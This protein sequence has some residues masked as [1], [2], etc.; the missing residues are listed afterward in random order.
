MKRLA[1]L[2]TVP[3]LA[4]LLIFTLSGSAA[5]AQAEI[6]PTGATATP[7]PVY[8]PPAGQTSPGPPPSRA[9]VQQQITICA[10]GPEYHHGGDETLGLA[11]FALDLP[12]GDY[13]VATITRGPSSTVEVCYL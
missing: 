12:P 8:Y 6:V 13:F 3:L 7:S 10:M 4:A 1:V 2:S 9:P 5:P 11:N